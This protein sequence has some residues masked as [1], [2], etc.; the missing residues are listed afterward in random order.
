MKSKIKTKDLTGRKF[1]RLTVLGIDET[2]ENTRRTYW[3]CQ[4]ECGNFKSV[5]SDSLQNG[6]IKSCGCLKREQDVINLDSHRYDIPA[7]GTRLYRIWTGIKSRCDDKNNPRY[8]DYGGRGIVLCDE[9]KN[10]FH[11]FYEWACSNGYKD[12]LTIDRINNDGNYC[13]KNCRWVDNKIQSLNRRSNIK[14]TI[15]N[16]TKTLTEWC[17]I[18]DLDSKTVFARLQRNEDISLDELFSMRKYRGNQ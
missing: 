9:W 4:C 7:V 11:S 15:G 5:R 16:T 12:D 17:E 10:D 8:S 14:I 3:F 1:G 6:S 18:F 13:P 2:N